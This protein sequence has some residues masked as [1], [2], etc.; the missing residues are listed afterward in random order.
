MGC[1]EIYPKIGDLRGKQMIK[2]WMEWGILFFRQARVI[3]TDGF[4]RSSLA[5][6]DDQRQLTDVLLGVL[7]FSAKHLSFLASTFRKV[8]SFVSCPI[9]PSLPGASSKSLCYHPDALWRSIT[10]P[11]NGK[12]IIFQQKRQGCEPLVGCHGHD[13]ILV[14]LLQH[15]SSGKN[16]LLCYSWKVWTST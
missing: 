16:M 15:R 8:R 12:T 13:Q 2:Q 9:R 11:G 7:Y 4:N 6:C 1:I 10:G 14:P 3:L 5:I